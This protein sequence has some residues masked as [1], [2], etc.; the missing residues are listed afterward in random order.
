ML[1]SLVAALI[2]YVI[3]ASVIDKRNRRKEEIL[4]KF[5]QHAPL[6]PNRSALLVRHTQQQQKKK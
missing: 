3:V 1:K 6:S 4:L 5:D 2:F